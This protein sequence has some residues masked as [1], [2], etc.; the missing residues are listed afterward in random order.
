MEGFSHLNET[1]YG[2]VEQ[3]ILIRSNLD[4]EVW[5]EKWKERYE[6]KLRQVPYDKNPLWLN[7]KKIQNTLDDNDDNDDDGDNNN[8]DEDDDDGDNGCEVR[9]DVSLV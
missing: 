9:I 1:V 7:R 8:Y 4:M 3:L 5:L 2:R 6:D